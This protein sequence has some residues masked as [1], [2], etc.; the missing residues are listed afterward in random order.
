MSLTENH[1]TPPMI[2]TQQ[3]TVTNNGNTTVDFDIVVNPTENSRPEPENSPENKEIPVSGVSKIKRD[4]CDAWTNTED[5][6]IANVTMGSIDNSSG[7]QGGVADFTAISTI[8]EAGTSQ[9]VTI[10]N[11][12]PWA[13]DM[14]TIWVDWNLDYEF[15]VASNEEF[16]LTNVGGTGYKFEGSVVVPFATLPGDYRMRIRMTYSAAPQPCG[17]ATYGEVEDYTITVPAGTSNSWLSADPI[18]G[19]IPP[20]QSTTINVTF[21]S[22][23]MTGG[24]YS[25]SI[26]FNSNDPVNPVITVPAILT[27]CG[28]PPC[29]LPPP[30]NL[31]GYEILPNIAFLSWQAP[32]PTGDL[33][34]Y[35]IY[36]NNEKI[37]PAIVSNLFYEDSLTNPS[38]YFYH[39]TA[40]Y[41]ECEASSDTIS[42]LITNLP[43]KENRGINIFPNP[44]TNF[45]NI[46]SQSSISQI[47]IINNFGQMV[48]EAENPGETIWVNT[49]NFPK[50]VYVVRIHT[51]K[52]ICFKK[53]IIN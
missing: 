6:Y 48:F 47:S 37:N 10:T 29:N 8:I 17:N 4:Y 35:N 22:E 5:E 20:G 36:R 52:G 33:L 1:P 50:G 43:E 23:G 30:Q 21:N 7:W 27:C 32:E 14:V 2:T 41:P 19:S 25:G 15:G 24:Y 18:S 9:N 46:K 53:L 16:I 49:S 40:V 3:L 12:T 42:L 11:G 34:G 38:Q 39:I 26:V 51:T 45:V 44:A 28:I 31:W 13:S